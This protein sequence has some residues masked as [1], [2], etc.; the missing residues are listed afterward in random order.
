MRLPPRRWLVRAKDGDPGAFRA[1]AVEQ[2]P[3]LFAAAFGILR[4]RELAQDATQQALINVWRYLRGLHDPGRFEGWSYRILVHACFAEARRLPTRLADT[5]AQAVSEPVARDEYARVDDRDQLERAFRRL[6]IDHRAVVVL[7]H[8][9]D[10]PVE[11]V[12]EAL[13]VKVGTVKSRL[14]RAM[15]ELRA[16]IEADAR[17]PARVAL[18]REG[19]R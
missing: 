1:L 19:A 16:A 10:L 14:H 12:A 9:A 5:D 18:G 13:D 2:H 8:L 7:H 6:S 15:D 11:T 17:T 3:R 4:D